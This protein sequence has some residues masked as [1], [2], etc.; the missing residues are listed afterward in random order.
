M[1][2]LT[3]VTFEIDRF[4]VNSPIYNFAIDSFHPYA[5]VKLDFKMS[6]TFNNIVFKSF[7][8]F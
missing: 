4:I 7:T 5:I 2:S 3:L 1:K 8:T 6:T